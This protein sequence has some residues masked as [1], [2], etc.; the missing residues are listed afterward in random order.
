MNRRLILCICFLF[1]FSPVFA[2]WEDVV[3]CEYMG[4]IDECENA[5]INGTPE[6]R[7]LKEW[8]A[9]FECPMISVSRNEFYEKIAYQVVLDIEFTKIDTEMDEYIGYLDENKDL[10]FWPNA[11]KNVLEGIN[12]IEAKFGEYWEYWKKYN[13]LCDGTNKEWVI[14]KSMAC[15]GG[16]TSTNW[17]K[18]FVSESTCQDIFIEK[19]LIYKSTAYKI[20]Q[21]NKSQ[22]RKDNK[23][24]FFQERRTKYD[25][26]YD[27]MMVNLGYMERIWRKWKS[28]IKYWHN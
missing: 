15:L 9:W 4:Q 20:L 1:F 7:S 14:Q 13:T 23:K 26:I 28:K 16:K 12:E 10:Y 21:L 3:S 19:L 24:E 25:A 22:V 17:A 27:A 6:P 11:Q 8:G 2:E 5:N 18:T